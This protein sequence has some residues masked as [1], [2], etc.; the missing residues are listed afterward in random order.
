ML[1]S[2]VLTDQ[3]PSVISAISF[4]NSRHSPLKCY[5]WQSVPDLHTSRVPELTGHQCDVSSSQD[6]HSAI[7]EAGARLVEVWALGHLLSPEL[8]DNRKAHW[9]GDIGPQEVGL[10]AHVGHHLCPLSH[11]GV[12][13]ALHLIRA[14]IQQDGVLVDQL[15]SLL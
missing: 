10:R 14:R 5:N 7:S 12:P 6:R 11:H 1:T 4:I 8:P 13:H 3:L 15:R 9:D 2:N